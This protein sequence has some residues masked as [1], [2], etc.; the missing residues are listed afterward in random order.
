MEVEIIK[1]N[2]SEMKNTLSKMKSILE[3]INR[4]DKEED[5]T[6]DIEDR[7]AKDIQSE[8][9]EKESQ[10]YNNNL[11]SLWDT[12]KYKKYPRHGGT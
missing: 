3:G 11:R 2:Q 12:I 8:W 7:E 9:Q 4:V 10:D 5:Q 6:T 1:R